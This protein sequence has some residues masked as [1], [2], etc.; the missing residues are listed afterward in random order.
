MKTITVNIDD[1][2]CEKAVTAVLDAL[3]LEYEIDDLTP[4]EDETARII[5][6]SY[7]ADK[8]TKGRKDMEEGKGTK[9]PLDETWK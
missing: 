2:L 9:I 7:L 5:A 8:I 1:S 6:N 3:R 4:F